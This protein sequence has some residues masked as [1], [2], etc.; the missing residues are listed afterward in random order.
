MHSPFDLLAETYDTDFTESAIGQLQRKQA[1]ELLHDVLSV[2]CKPMR[3]LEINCGTGED[4]LKLAGL[5][6]S[7][8][9]TDASE[10]M[11][12]KAKQKATLP[13][14]NIQFVVC[15]FDDLYGLLNQES[16]D[17]VISNFGGLN[18]IDEIALERLARTLSAM[19]VPG[20]KLFLVMLSRNCLWEMFYFS[21]KGRIKTALRRR[22]LALFNA[23]GVSMPVYYYSPKTVRK[24]FKRYYTHIRTRPVGLIV[25]P[26]Y[27]EK[28]FIKHQQL[29]H[30]LADL[31]R[32]WSRYAAL[33][34][35]ADH[36]C[37]IF[38]KKN[39]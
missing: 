1:W 17:M 32:K 23:G 26:S 11:I 12:Q 16:F 25:P 28:Q 18:C 8:V 13:G 2:S 35:L 10:V 31:D 29:L 24:I 7:V 21:L 30:R 36:F 38:Q 14:Q 9:A 39:P 3:I 20:G 33:A 5:G 4:A 37:I 19:L 27:L 22:Q 6:H 15:P 34:N